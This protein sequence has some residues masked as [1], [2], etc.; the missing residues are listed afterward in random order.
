MGSRSFCV[1][2]VVLWWSCP[3]AARQ[4]EAVQVRA[5]AQDLKRL[6]IEELAEL[7]V[8]TAARRVQR[9]SDTA[10]AVSV[11]REEDIRRSGYTNL[12]DALR[13]ADGLDVARVNSS[14]WAISARG[15][16]INPS[17]KM[18]VLF[19]GRS[20]YSP[21]TGGTSWDAQDY[22]LADID[23]IEVIRGPG[24]A[25]WGANAVNGVINI[26]TRNASATRGSLAAVTAGTDEHATVALRHGGRV[27]E[28]G[29]YRVY[30]RYR[31]KGAQVFATGADANNPVQLGQTGFRMDSGAEGADRWTLQG[32]VYRGTQ[33]FPDRPDGDTAG[34]NILGRWT[35]RFSGTSDLQV[36]ASYDRTYRNVP[37]QFRATRD[38]WDLDLQHTRRAGGRHDIV[39][40][41]GFRV[42]HGDERGIAGFFFEPE[43]KTDALFNVFIQDEIALAPA[44]LFLTLGT[45]LERNDFT[46]FENQPTV[47]LRWSAGGAQTLWGAV[48]RAVRLPTRLDTDLRLI[49]PV[50]RALILEG[51]RVFRSEEVI[52]YEA[53]YRVRP[54]ALL[55]F[56][57]AAFANRY[58]RLRTTDLV[59]RPA[60]VIVLQNRLEA[61]T[62]GVELAVTSQ[63]VHPWQIQGSYAF[64]NKDLSFADGVPDVYVGTVEG[65]DPSHILALRS[66]LTLPRGFAFDT[67]VRHTSSRPAPTTPPHTEL[68]LRLGWTARTGWEL[69]LAGQN[70]LDRYHPELLTESQ[71][72]AF[73]RGVYLRSV[74]RF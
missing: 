56:D 35:R 31:R 22:V 70:L 50:T 45:K 51:S 40:G 2:A 9:L 64:L 26:T 7:D 63:P 42:S 28:G 53:G 29:S 49:N 5:S 46:G 3:S 18:L 21:L 55:S 69:S 43:Q 41:G 1:L 12:A 23:R 73:R 20:L 71:K 39:A 27:G 61:V 34:G 6:S 24:G 57:V 66:Y 13:L 30:G 15:F 14:T 11:I 44:R 62:S 37:R 17:N 58:D 72:F 19:D 4:H 10:A 59:F 74:W 8:R 48:S 47:R 33:G 52:A 25:V 38:T 16:N 65:N 67:V 36:Q 54:H 32:D 60:P 68:N